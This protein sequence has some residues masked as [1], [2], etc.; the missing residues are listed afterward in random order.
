MYRYPHCGRLWS[1]PTGI[2]QTIDYWLMTFCKLALRE[3]NGEPF[4]AAHIEIVDKLYDS[5]GVQ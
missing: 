4:Q 2:G 3:I 5:H 1:K